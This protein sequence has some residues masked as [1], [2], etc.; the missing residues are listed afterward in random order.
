M[1]GKARKVTIADIA[2]EA[3]VSVPTVSKVM[4]GRPDVAAATR[5]RVE[6]I[7]R[8]HGY[9][10]RTDERYRKSNLLEL[11]FHELESSWALEI[12]RGVQKV[13]VENGMAVVLS[14]SQGLLRPGQSWL[15]NV[16]AR[17]PVGVIAVFSDLG[18]DQLAKLRARDIPVVVV[19]PVG[20]PTGQTHSVGATNWQGGLTATRHLIDLGH[21]RIAMIGGPPNVLCSRA[22]VDG[23]RAALETAGLTVDPDLVRYGD[24]HVEAGHKQMLAL[25]ALDNRPTA[26]FAGSDLQA[27]GV[28]EAARA[29]GLRI[30]EDLS[31]IGFDDLPV[32]RWVGPPLTTVRQPLR[33]MAAAGARMAITLTGGGQVEHHRVELATSLVVRSS[34]AAYIRK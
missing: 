29:A 9:Q 28:Y 18:A 8:K 21:K 13:A 26:V 25:L 5:Q 34:T 1:P 31:V 4:N 23:Y 33:E 17:R 2:T 19:D 32:A 22:R 20:E 24:F 14:E 11:M 15:E 30:P 12:I 6:E 16:L 27:V 10:R 7:I 3:G